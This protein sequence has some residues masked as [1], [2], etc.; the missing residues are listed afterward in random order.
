M[1][2]G[3]YAW[4]TFNDDFPQN[5]AIFYGLGF[6]FDFKFAYISNSLRGLSGYMFNGDQPIV[7]Y[8]EIGIREGRTAFTLGYEWGI[9]DYPFKCIR[10]GFKLD[11]MIE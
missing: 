5:D 3:F 8:S 1:L 11:G 6:D 4:Q 7:Y 2:G 10:L 9:V